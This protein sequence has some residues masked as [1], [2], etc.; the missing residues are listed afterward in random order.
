[1]SLKVQIIKFAEK[2]SNR[3][4]RCHFEP[5]PMEKM[6]RAW[7]SQEDVLFKLNKESEHSAGKVQKFSL[8]Q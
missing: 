1:M 8:L 5:L 2:H 7:W 6:I 3:S 4:A